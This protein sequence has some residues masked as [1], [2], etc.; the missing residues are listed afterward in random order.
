MR[1]QLDPVVFTL[2]RRL[3]SRALAAVTVVGLLSGVANGL[4]AQAHWVVA[5][6]AAADQWFGAVAALDLPVPGSLRFYVPGARSSPAWRDAAAEAPA[7]E[8]LHF[9]PLY[10][11]SATPAE[12]IGA[13][14][15]ASEDRPAP[16]SRA[17]L[18]VAAL[19][20]TIERPRDRELL[21]NFATFAERARVGPTLSKERLETLQRAWDS[22]FAPAL[23]P[24]L[25]IR[26]LDGGLLLV[27][28]SIAAEGRI[29]TGRWA[30]RTDN[31]IA[32][33]DHVGI[34]IPEAP[35]LA[36][37][38]ELCAPLVTELST[39]V[40][41][42]TTRAAIA[43]ALHDDPASASRASVRCGAALLDTALP[44]R[45]ATYRALWARLAD[46]ARFADAFPP[47]ATADAS[48]GTA[49]RRAFASSPAR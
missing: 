9:A 1:G 29:F 6:S 12:L 26:R 34:D 36:A 39:T 33:G 19:Q 5:R 27:V 23:A 16:A 4:G 10:Y 20:Q 15:A 38:R 13:A 37:V 49:I 31:V 47:D 2:A 24:F 48:I 35:L 46:V 14:R 25:S 32:V 8:I 21:A 3:R 22:T 18:L 11:P 30:D 43:S 44:S 17:T 45:A 41:S 40:R 7:L 28:P 42:R